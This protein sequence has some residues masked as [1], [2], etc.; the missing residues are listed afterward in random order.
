MPARRGQIEGTESVAAIIVRVG[1][2]G[3][4]GREAEVEFYW[5]RDASAIDTSGR[6]PGKFV[7]RL[8]YRFERVD[9]AFPELSR[10]RAAD[11]RA[12]RSRL[13]RLPVVVLD[14]WASVHCWPAGAHV[15]LELALDEAVH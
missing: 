15:G 11:A 4:I 8:Q 3:S 7:Q 1:E 6:G 14:L 12:S 10:A 9:T 5:L 2:A 13:S